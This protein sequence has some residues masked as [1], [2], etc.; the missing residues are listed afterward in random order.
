MKR[1]K[2]SV[3]SPGVPLFIRVAVPPMGLAAAVTVSVALSTSVSP[4]SNVLTEVSSVVSSV[5]VRV[6][7][8]A[9]GGSLTGVTVMATESVSLLAPP[10]PVKP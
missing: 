7:S 9:V 5:A 6:S 4:V 10:V 8:S 2:S 3:V 1:T